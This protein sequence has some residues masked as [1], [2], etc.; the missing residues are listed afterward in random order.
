MI[1]FIFN[2]YSNLYSAI[3]TSSYTNFIAEVFMIKNSILKN[4]AL[5]FSFLM[6]APALDKSQI[7]KVM[8]AYKSSGVVADSLEAEIISVIT[9]DLKVVSKYISDLET[10]SPEWLSKM[11]EIANLFND[12]CYLPKGISIIGTDGNKALFDGVLL[13]YDVTPITK[14]YE[15]YWIKQRL[16]QEANR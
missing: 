3:Y 1:R 11:K 6:L 9:Q 13:Y 4:I 16:I 2:I 5:A 8:E 15:A 12:G 14:I 10:H 7:N